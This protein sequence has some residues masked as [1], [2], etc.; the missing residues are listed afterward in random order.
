MR[1]QWAEVLVNV[2]YFNENNCLPK[3]YLIFF[4]GSCLLL[5]SLDCNYVYTGSVVS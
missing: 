4:S 3:N 1:Y 2:F 5:R